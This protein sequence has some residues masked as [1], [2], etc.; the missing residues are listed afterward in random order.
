MGQDPRSSASTLCPALKVVRYYF[1]LD[2]ECFS[3]IH[4]STFLTSSHVRTKAAATLGYFVTCVEVEF[5][6]AFILST[7]SVSS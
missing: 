5:L 3:C 4:L 7:G 1:Q 6:P 2:V